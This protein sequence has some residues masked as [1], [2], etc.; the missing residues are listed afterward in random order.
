MNTEEFK[1]SN[2]PKQVRVDDTDNYKAGMKIT[3]IGHDRPFIIM[4]VLNEYD[5]TVIPLGVVH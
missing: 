2:I 1:Q 3:F 4:D 5:I